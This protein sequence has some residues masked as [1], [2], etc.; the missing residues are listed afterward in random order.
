MIYTFTFLLL[1]DLVQKVNMNSVFYLQSASFRMHLST[2]CLL[3][4]SVDTC[5]LLVAC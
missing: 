5:T 2:G 3:S 4:A 1:V